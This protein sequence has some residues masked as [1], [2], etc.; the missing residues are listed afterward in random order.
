MSG[1]W[2]NGEVVPWKKGDLVGI[3][4]HGKDDQEAALLIEVV[5]TEY[6]SDNSYR[7][8]WKVLNSEATLSYLWEDQIYP[9][10]M[11][12]KPSFIRRIMPQ[13]IAN[14]IVSVQP[15][16]APSGKIFTYMYGKDDE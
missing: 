14:E 8:K 10:G 15:M 4:R 11:A 5:R 12:E 9:L 3:W 6:T 1:K 16:T 7:L 13:L 2:E